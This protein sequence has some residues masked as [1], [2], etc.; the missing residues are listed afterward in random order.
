MSTLPTTIRHR[1]ADG[2]EGWTMHDPMAQR[3]RWLG[4]EA[5]MLGGGWPVL[6]PVAPEPPYMIRATLSGGRAESYVGC[7]FHLADAENHE[8]I[9][10][11]PYLGGQPEAIQYDP[12]IN[13]STTWQVF[14][15]ADGIATAPLRREHWHLLRVDLWADI[16]Q[17]Y[18]DDEGLPQATFP[19][20][21]GLRRGRVG[22]WGYNPC[23]VADFEVRPL[24]AIAPPVPEPK[25][26][27]PP[28]TVREWLVA[29]CDRRSRAL[30]EPRKATSEHNGT[31]C[32]NRLC[33]AEPGARALTAC[34][35][36]VSPGSQQAVLEIG[37]SDRARVWLNNAL[38]HEG[39][40][41]WD[42]EAGTDG[43]IRPGQTKIPIAS[44]PGS[45][46][47]LIEITALEPGFG[48]G[49]TARALADGN[50]CQW[51]PATTLERP[52]DL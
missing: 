2:I 51:R 34:E 37:Y 27:V 8:T 29:R 28:G 18:V 3:V 39:E 4:R 26:T 13:G 24:E 42:P 6:A 31:L 14:G 9:Y 45:H 15:D 44:R 7:C 47:L 17:V 36:E 20:R 41:R 50:P 35:V 46:L 25:V 19:L 16:A 5:L 11:A 1:F 21:S 23:Y 12:V 43:R 32:L 38:V 22:L 48:W 33:G 49:L 10:L 40:W 52:G 30:L